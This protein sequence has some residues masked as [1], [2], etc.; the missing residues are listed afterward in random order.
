MFYM[1][2]S[3]MFYSSLGDIFDF[4]L[5]T[6]IGDKFWSRLCRCHL[7][8]K[9]LLLWMTEEILSSRYWTNLSHKGPYSS[10]IQNSLT[11]SKRKGAQN[12]W[13]NLGLLMTFKSKVINRIQAFYTGLTCIPY[14][15]VK[16]LSHSR[17]SL[18][19]QH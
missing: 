6:W 7:D 15:I 11:H 14:L 9:L 19:T 2:A 10:S 12:P 17:K 18:T 8:Y 13:E 3:S 16:L 5:C 4:H 1:R